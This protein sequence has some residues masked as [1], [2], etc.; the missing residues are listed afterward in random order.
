MI[1]DSYLFVP[2]EDIPVEPLT[3]GLSAVYLGG[4]TQTQKSG[5]RPGTLAALGAISLITHS[6]LSA[7]RGRILSS[8]TKVRGHAIKT[9][10]VWQGSG[11]AC[12]TG[13]N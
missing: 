11:F 7:G 3:I 12:V 5:R 10:F 8:A 6:V 13:L 2:H 1:Y 4:I 9:R